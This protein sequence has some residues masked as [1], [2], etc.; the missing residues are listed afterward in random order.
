MEPATLVLYVTRSAGVVMRSSGVP[1]RATQTIDAGQPSLQGQSAR[2]PSLSQ[3][4]RSL[5]AGMSQ[6]R[7]SSNPP[8]A[9]RPRVAAK[10]PR[11]GFF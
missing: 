3:S 2:T 7:A 11:R 8:A 4:R 9:A 1:C 6:I 10:P 5:L